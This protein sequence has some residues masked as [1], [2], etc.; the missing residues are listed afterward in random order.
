M[1]THLL[2]DGPLRCLRADV[3]DETARGGHVYAATAGPD[4][5][6]KEADDD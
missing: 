5:A 1:C 4:L 3:H 2:N 6:R